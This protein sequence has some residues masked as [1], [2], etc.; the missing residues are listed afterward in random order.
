MKE[1]LLSTSEAEAD[2]L[3]DLLTS[4][5]GSLPRVNE[6]PSLS[7]SDPSSFRIKRGIGAFLFRGIFGTFMGLYNHRK[8][9]NLREQVETVAA[10]QHRLLQITAVTL[11]RLDDLKYMMAETMK[12]ISE[13][14][15]ITLTQQ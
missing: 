15:N 3:L 2:K 10:R 12:L 7:M 11:I 6:A 8:L 9:S 14:I 4:L 13:D 1:D 5:R